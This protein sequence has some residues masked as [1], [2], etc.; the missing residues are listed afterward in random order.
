MA[1]AEEKL[2]EAQQ[3][4][5]SDCESL[6]REEAACNT[7]KLE[8]RALAQQ[9]ASEGTEWAAGAQ[10]RAAAAAQAARILAEA[11]R[12]RVRPVDLLQVSLGGVQACLP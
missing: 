1:A 10:G 9:L 2:A 12:F 3:S 6:Q 11:D 8:T 5:A 4:L 7:L